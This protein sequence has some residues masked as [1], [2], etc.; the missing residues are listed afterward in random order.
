MT[1]LPNCFDKYPLLSLERKVVAVRVYL[2]LTIRNFVSPFRGCT[3]PSKGIIMQLMDQARWVG[4]PSFSHGDCLR[5]LVMQIIRFYPPRRK[6][7]KPF[8]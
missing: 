3:E 1:Q 4:D 2:K 6:E 5:K 8:R 7:A